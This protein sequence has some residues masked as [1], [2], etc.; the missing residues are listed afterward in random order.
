[1]V[2]LDFRVSDDWHRALSCLIW[3]VRAPI[4]AQGSSPA[5]YRRKQSPLAGEPSVLDAPPGGAAAA[6]GSPARPGAPPPPRALARR[7][8]IANVRPLYSV[9]VPSDSDHYA[10]TPVL[11]IPGSAAE[12]RPGARD[13]LS[14]ASMP[15]YT[16]PG[17]RNAH[18]HFCFDDQPQH[19][20]GAV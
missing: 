15:N 13:L 9:Y 1:M 11:D 18:F 17:N 12:G 14:V 6:G 19:S 10:A 20:S 4:C 16:S 8:G 7:H 2:V 3:R 5:A